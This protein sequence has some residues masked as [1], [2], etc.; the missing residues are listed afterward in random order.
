[1]EFNINFKI[2]PLVVKID[3]NP[4]FT[5]AI[6]FLASAFGY[7]GK[8]IANELKETAKEAKAKAEEQPKQQQIQMQEQPQKQEAPKQE[9]AKTVENWTEKSITPILSGYL[10]KGVTNDD[11]RKE[12]RK[13]KDKN[14]NPIQGIKQLIQEKGK[15]EIDQFLKALQ[16]Y[17]KEDLNAG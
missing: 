12:L 11:M 4:Q 6:C 5:Q 10:K 2:D 3:V 17:F 15:E 7:P 8:T 16:V 14:N 13:F 9:E 1:M